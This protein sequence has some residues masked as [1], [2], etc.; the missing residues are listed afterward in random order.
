MCRQQGNNTLNNTKTNTAPPE[1]NGSI[2]R[3]EHSNADEA[4]ENNTKNNFMKMI[5]AL[6]EE[7]KISLKEMDEKANTKLDEIKSLKET[8]EKQSSR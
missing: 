5:E 2:E 4:E 6:K 3:P 8:Q 7:M 1:T